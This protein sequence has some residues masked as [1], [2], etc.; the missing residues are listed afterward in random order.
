MFIVFKGR[1]NRLAVPFMH[2]QGVV[3][4]QKFCLVYLPLLPA[5]RLA[6]RAGLL[7]KIALRQPP[8]D[9]YQ[10]TLTVQAQRKPMPMHHNRQYYDCRQWPK[11]L[12]VHVR[13]MLLYHP[14]CKPQAGL[15]V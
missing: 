10:N 1:L 14:R 15:A 6:Y 4:V 8:L 5:L 11:H 9:F 3:P 7:Q 13:Q 12:H 2:K